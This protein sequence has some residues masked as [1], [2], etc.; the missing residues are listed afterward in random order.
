MAKSIPRIIISG[1]AG[2]LLFLILLAIANVLLPFINNSN[3]SGA[4]DFVNN[5]IIL[6]FIIAFIGIINDIFWSFYFPFNIIAPVTGALLSVYIIMFLERL[7]NFF[8]T[9]LS[10]KIIIPFSE[11]YF[12]VA[13]I[14][15][16]AGY[17]II[18]ARHGRP[19]GDFE[20]RWKERHKIRLKRRKERLED[21]IKELSRE[22]KNIKWEDVGDEFKQALYN[23]GKSIN[24][25]FEEKDKAKKR[26]SKKR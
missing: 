23:L 16:I 20:E 21:E 8:N 25:L 18:A 5:N 3:Y 12:L 26:G 7:F 14:V 4:V 17:I 22:V 15:F 11:L 2:F 9:R 10:T 24:N 13:L 1:I 19:R 6:F